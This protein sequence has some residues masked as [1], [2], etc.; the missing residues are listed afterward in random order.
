MMFRHPD[1]KARAPYFVA[2]ESISAHGDARVTRI[3][4]MSD[5]S[6][7]TG[8]QYYLAHARNTVHA[9][10]DLPGPVTEDAFRA[11]V[12]DVV[13]ATPH[14]LWR[15][16]LRDGGHH[17]DTTGDWSGQYAFISYN[18][19]ALAPPDLAAR[20]AE[21]LHDTDRP[22]FRAI[23]QIVPTAEGPRAR[24]TFQT[25][26]ALM[27]GGDVADLLRGRG[28]ERAARPTV[29][30]QIPLAARLAVWLV[31]PLFWI[32]NLT[33]AALER[34]DRGTF[35]MARIVISRV[36]L[37]KAARRAGISQRDLA[38]ALTTH[39][40]KAGKKAIF[41]AY[42]N[43]PPARIHLCDDEFLSVR[44]D[45]VRIPL[46]TDF[47]SYAKG[48]SETLHKRGPSPMFTQM[49]YRRINQVHRWLHSRAPRLYPKALFG[50]APYDVV[51]S[52]LP[53]VRAGQAFPLLE[54]ARVFTG[55][56]T[57]TAESCIFAMSK[58]EVTISLWSGADRAANVDAIL[59]R[60][61]T[62]GIAAE[63]AA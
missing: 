4:R 45:E 43:R 47:E 6:R 48:L 61:A 52:L 1:R 10:L 15:E 41:A 28:T 56:D 51:L 39:H 62:L 49:W 12:G 23:C 55:S 35:A 59:D 34:K 16:S 38:F 19:A 20:M 42:S 40:R 7:F 11:L 14:L 3:N 18:D 22:A 63:V 33:M 58:D 8:L 36:D 5:F 27:E 54:G 26:H 2:S 44:M 53:P 57:G 13:E 21:P 29:S 37:R 46:S 31:I 32:I 60:A 9:V 50:F 17:R 25:T 24:I 30:A